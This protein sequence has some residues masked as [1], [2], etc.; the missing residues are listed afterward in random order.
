VSVILAKVGH[1][2]RHGSSAPWQASF[3][4]WPTAGVLHRCNRALALL[5]SGYFFCP[6]EQSRR[7]LTARAIPVFEERYDR[8]PVISASNSLF[9]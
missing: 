4:S 8:V 5:T 6:R 2:R 3:W 1:G 9:L 7:R